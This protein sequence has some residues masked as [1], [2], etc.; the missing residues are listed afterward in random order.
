MQ[1]ACWNAGRIGTGALWVGTLAVLMSMHSIV[2]G[3]HRQPP[4]SG[5]TVTVLDLGTYAATGKIINNPTAATGEIS[6]NYSLAPPPLTVTRNIP[7]KVG[8][9]FGFRF[10]L[11]GDAAAVPLTV[12]VAHPPINGKT[13]TTYT[14]DTLD[15]PTGATHGAFYSIETEAEDVPGEWVIEILHDGEVLA[16]EVFTLE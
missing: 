5:P 2:A 7:A 10:W 9:L 11:E 14:L 16:R 1:R 8:T 15:A 12:R 4:P 6:L 13:F 3:C